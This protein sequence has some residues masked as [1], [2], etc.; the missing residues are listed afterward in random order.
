M[1]TTNLKLD[2][3][4]ALPKPGP[5]GRVVRLAFGLLCVWYV[6]GLL[7]VSGSLI[8][9]DGNIRAIVWNGRPGIVD[10]DL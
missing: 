1:A 4:G 5:V 9:G 7:D 10:Q 2:E 8:A 6:K 3:P